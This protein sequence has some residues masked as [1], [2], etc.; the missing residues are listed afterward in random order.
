MTV[1][2]ALIALT[3]PAARI[4]E[5]VN[6]APDS[7]NLARDWVVQ[8]LPPGWTVVVPSELGL[9]TRGL[10]DHDFLVQE[11]SVTTLQSQKEM[12][13]MV[14][15]QVVA[16]VPVW[17]MDGRFS[18]RADADEMNATTA[19]KRTLAEFGSNQ[20]LINYEPAAAWGDPRIFVVAP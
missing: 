9:D 12:L 19:G 16:L 18:A 3:L 20:V 5:H 2:L 1:L 11:V 13:A 15:G 14:E 7:R 8:N 6:V 4:I 17:G 10:E